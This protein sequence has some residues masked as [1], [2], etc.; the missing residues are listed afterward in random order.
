MVSRGGGSLSRWSADGKELFYTE[1]GTIMAVDVNA[2]KAFHAGVPRK[3]FDAPGALN[4]F[5]ITRGGKRFLFVVAQQSAGAPP[6]FT[7][8]LNWTAGLK[9]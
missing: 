1:G 6:S 5:D 8:L 3:L 2:D 7:V 9:K 4:G